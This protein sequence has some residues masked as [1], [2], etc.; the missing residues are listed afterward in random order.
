MKTQFSLL[1][2]LYRRASPKTPFSNVYLNETPQP[3]NPLSQPFSTPST[4]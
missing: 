4:P 3:I 1:K 2:L